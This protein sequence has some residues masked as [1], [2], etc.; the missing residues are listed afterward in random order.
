MATTIGKTHCVSCGKEKIAYR[1]EG[2]SQ[3]FC[4]NHL[5]D[6]HREL[7]LRLSDVE[8]K[9]NLFQEKIAEQWNNPQK[10]LLVQEINQWEIDSLS[11]IRQTAEDAREVL[12]KH[13]RENITKIEDTLTQLSRELKEARAEYDF[14]EWHLNQFEEKLKQ[15]EEQLNK[16]STISIQRDSSSFIYR[17]FVTISSDDQPTAAPPPPPPSPRRVIPQP[18]TITRWTQNGITV[19]GG[20]GQGSAMNQ[21]S[22]PFYVYVDDDDQTLHVAD[23]ENHRIIELKNGESNG[24]VVAGGNGAGGRSDQL[25]CPTIA[26]IDKGN[27]SLIICDQGNQRI[28][29]WPRR[30]EA[31]GEIIVSQ[32]DCYDL[33]MDNN[34]Y[35]FVADRN[36]HTIRRYRVDGTEGTIVAG[37]NGI[38]NGLNQFN[39]P[40]FIWVDQ[41][42]TLYV[43]DYG[44][45]RIMKWANGAK[46]GVLVAGSQGPGNCP[47]QLCAPRGIIVD[48]LGTLYIADSG[49]FR[50]MRWFKGATEG[51]AVIGAN[52]QGKNANQFYNIRGLA[53]DRDRNLYAVDTNNHRVQKF[54]IEPNSTA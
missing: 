38:G 10:Q 22:C 3:N 51:S 29:R 1:C 46:E 40:R 25:N 34:G 27:D 8:I 7:G 11:L 52:G 9:R 31:K 14:N 20:H 13:A 12:A 45:H 19:A 36:S 21:L 39:Q 44:N 16:P 53:F 2:C 17:I 32:I 35:F 48:Q 23:R 47:G 50:V 30:K 6:H 33:R 49:N 37:G 24:R 43:S 54:T 28:L 5:A 41:N 18:N 26:V 4:V 42:H 15:L